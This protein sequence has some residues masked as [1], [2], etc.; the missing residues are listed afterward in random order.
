[1]ISHWIGWIS[2]ASCILLLAKVVGRISKNKEL[3]QFLRKF[4]KPL[5]IAVI[6]LGAIHGILCFAENSQAVISI[7][8]GVILLLCIIAMARTYFVRT[9]F[10]AKWFQMHRHLSI[11]LI[12]IMVLHIIVSI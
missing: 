4:H 10:K 2:F 11:I 12:V 9:K 1:M 6:A 5:G 7:I 3:N 8:T